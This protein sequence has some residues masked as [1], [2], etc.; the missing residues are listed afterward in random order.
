[1][2]VIWKYTLQ[3][4]GEQTLMLP[5]R[6]VVLH[7]DA[8]GEKVCLWAMV[9]DRAPADAAVRVSVRGTGEPCESVASTYVGTVMLDGGSLVWH[10]FVEPEP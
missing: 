1:M 5:R 2:R 3:A 10:V 4:T 8:Q 9:D 7:A 6:S